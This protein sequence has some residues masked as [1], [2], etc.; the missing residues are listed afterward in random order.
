MSRFHADALTRD[1]QVRQR[2]AEKRESRQEKPSVLIHIQRALIVITGAIV[3]V[4]MTVQIV[5]RYVFGFSIYGI[6]EAMSF[7]AIW[8]YFMGSAHGAWDRGHISADLVDVLF[9]PGKVQQALR[10]LASALTV[11]ICAWMTTWAAQYLINSIQRNL[12]SLEV[13]VPLAWVNAAMPLGLGLMTFYFLIE[14][15]E[16]W[17]IFRGIE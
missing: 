14:L 4:L 6:E 10:V 9:R 12:T 2:I 5:T 17:Q 15:I 7:F 16:E 1:T 3:T 8:L 13:G 11:V